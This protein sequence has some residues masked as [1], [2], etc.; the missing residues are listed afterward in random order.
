LQT[1]Q[2]KGKPVRSRGRNDSLPIHE[3]LL[4][5]P[6]SRSWPTLSI[7]LK[8]RRSVIRDRWM[9]NIK[10]NPNVYLFERQDITLRYCLFEIKLGVLLAPQCSTHLPR[11]FLQAFNYSNSQ[12]VLWRIEIPCQIGRWNWSVQTIT[13][14]L[15]TRIWWYRGFGVPVVPVFMPLVKWRS[16]IQTEREL[17][18]PWRKVRSWLSVFHVDSQ[19]FNQLKL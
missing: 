6:Q 7:Q 12:R 19:L 13:S 11:R 3:S 1:R 9:N 2:T 4:Y 14:G 8:M 5:A 18:L 16:H 10:Y 15:R 17:G